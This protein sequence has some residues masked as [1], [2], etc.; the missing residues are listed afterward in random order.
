VVR[1]LAWV[2]RILPVALVPDE[3]QLLVRRPWPVDSR[4]L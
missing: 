2:N 3:A 4:D 1:A